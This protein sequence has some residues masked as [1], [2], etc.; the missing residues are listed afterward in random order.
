MRVEFILKNV[1]VIMTLK[2]EYG[3]WNYNWLLLH[4]R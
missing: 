2:I 3:D 1:V 4:Y